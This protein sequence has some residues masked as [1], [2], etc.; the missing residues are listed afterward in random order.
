MKE[1]EMVLYFYAV[2]S[3]LLNRILPG[4]LRCPLKI[5]GWIRYDSM[6][7]LYENRPFLWK[8]LVFGGCIW[9]VTFY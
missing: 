4:K 8:M 3:D 6:Y 7:F 9:C 2:P 1:V 5:N